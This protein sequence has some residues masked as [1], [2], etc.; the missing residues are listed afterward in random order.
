MAASTKR[1]AEPFEEAIARLNVESVAAF[2]RGDIAA[3]AGFY[4]EDATM[5]LPDRPPVRGRAA[6]ADCLRGFAAAGMTL[7]PVAPVAVV[8][9]GDI[10]CCAGLH[11]FRAPD[12]GGAAIAQAGKFVTVLRR[13]P[14][15]TWK[16]AIDSFF[17]DTA[18]A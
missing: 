10:G 12:G 4:E 11:R 14:D 16:A 2:N 15:G 1:Q 9:G 13:Q 17:A 5:L 18:P 3:C 7:M 8:S 6:I